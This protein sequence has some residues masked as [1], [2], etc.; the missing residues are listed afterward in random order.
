MHTMA[1][2]VADVTSSCHAEMLAAF[3]SA[4]GGGG[5]DGAGA[6]AGCGRARGLLG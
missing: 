2:G 6:P 1:V 3:M 5:G 4:S